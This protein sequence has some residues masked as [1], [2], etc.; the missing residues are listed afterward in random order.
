MTVGKE[1]VR[2]RKI[3][4]NQKHEGPAAAPAW[5]VEV[6]AAVIKKTVERLRSHFG[7]AVSHRFRCI[8]KGQ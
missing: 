3:C 6:A 2:K 1:G 7:I 5:A 4:V 8:H